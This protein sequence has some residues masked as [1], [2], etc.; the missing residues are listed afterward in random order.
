MVSSNRLVLIAVAAMGFCGT[1][2]DAAGL[3][4]QFH[5]TWAGDLDQ[6][7]LTGEHARLKIDRRFILGYEHGWTIRRWRSRNGVW[8]GRGTADDDQGS[9]PATVRLRMGRDGRLIFNDAAYLRCPD[10][11]GAD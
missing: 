3:P 8:T 9:E 4:R 2:A 7:A 11:T 5:G 10:R 6:C 1:P